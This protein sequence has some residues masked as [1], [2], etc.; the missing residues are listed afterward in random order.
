MDPEKKDRVGNGGIWRWDS[1]SI[2]GERRGLKEPP[3]ELLS[4]G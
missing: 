4:E 2:G 1:Y 3:I